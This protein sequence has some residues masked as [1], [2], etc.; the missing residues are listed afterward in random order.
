[1]KKPSDAI[2]KELPLKLDDGEVPYLHGDAD[3]C[4]VCPDCQL[5]LIEGLVLA[6]TLPV[7]FQCPDC[8]IWLVV[9][10][11]WRPSEPPYTST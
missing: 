7:A 2:I 8:N 10:S 1:M 3:V 4:Y 9:A 6:R 5:V 11:E